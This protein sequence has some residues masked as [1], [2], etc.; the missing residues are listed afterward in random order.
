MNISYLDQTTSNNELKNSYIPIKLNQGGIMPLVFSST[1]ATFLYYPLQLLANL[2][3]HV[4]LV[5]EEL[6]SNNGVDIFVSLLTST[7][8]K[9]QELGHLS[10]LTIRMLLIV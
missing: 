3:R 5:C 9:M 10:Y 1:I 2:I 6:Y 7:K 4:R 8:V